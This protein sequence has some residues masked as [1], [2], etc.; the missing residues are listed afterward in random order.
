MVLNR[1]D[2]LDRAMREGV[3]LAKAGLQPP[4]PPGDATIL[5]PLRKQGSMPP[6]VLANAG[7]QAVI[8]LSP[9]TWLRPKPR[10]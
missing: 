10:P 9:S 6:A 8:I 2:L 1:F 5:S 4:V 7:T 3:G